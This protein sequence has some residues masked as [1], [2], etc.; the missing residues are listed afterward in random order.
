MATHTLNKTRCY[1][2][3]HMQYAEPGDWREYVKNELKKL[4]LFF[5]IH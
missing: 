4:V 2:V 1:L 3:G 5:I